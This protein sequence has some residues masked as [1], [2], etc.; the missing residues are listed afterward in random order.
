MECAGSALAFFQIFKSR[1]EAGFL[2]AGG[3][4]GRFPSGEIKEVFSALGCWL[5]SS[6]V[7]LF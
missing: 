4:G 2:T 3:R 7:A 5:L 1:L 6:D